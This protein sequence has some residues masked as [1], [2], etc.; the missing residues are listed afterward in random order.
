MNRL[1]KLRTEKN[2]SQADVA[3]ILNVSARAIGLYENEERDIPTE[4]LI[5][6]AEYFK[7]STD[8]ILGLTNIRNQLDIPVEIAA[9]TKNGIDLSDVSD[10]D[11]EIIMNIINTSKKDNN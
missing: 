6:L 10:R 9:S 3:K 11:K 4:Y 2:L 1:K 5:K 8:Y 7:V